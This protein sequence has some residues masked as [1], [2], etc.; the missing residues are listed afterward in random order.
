LDESLGAVG[1]AVSTECLGRRVD[2]FHDESEL[3][4]KLRR[5]AD[6][7]GAREFAGQLAEA[8]ADPGLN[9]R[10]RSLALSRTGRVPEAEE[11]A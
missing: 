8:T 9:V 6:P 5:V 2:A 7:A 4:G 11:I 3:V 1:R 10:E